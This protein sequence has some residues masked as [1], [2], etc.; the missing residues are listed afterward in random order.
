MENG[1]AIGTLP[2]LP[3]QTNWFFDCGNL[4]T[5]H[6]SPED[7]VVEMTVA[8]LYQCTSPAGPV[9]QLLCHIHMYGA[10]TLC[11]QVMT[12]PI[13]ISSSDSRSPNDVI[14]GAASQSPKCDEAA[15]SLAMSP[16]AWSPRATVAGACRCRAPVFLFVI[17]QIHT[18]MPTVPE[19]PGSSRS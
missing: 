13:L 2:I 14:G 9:H 18:G 17:K 6:G 3:H 5:L 19:W 16:A 11:I 1:G 7:D 10:R 15:N 8:L 4:C 12:S